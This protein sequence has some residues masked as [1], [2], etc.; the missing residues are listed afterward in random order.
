MPVGKESRLVLSD[1]IEPGP[2]FGW[3]APQSLEFL[4]RPSNEMLVDAHGQ[5][6][7]L[8]AIE[9]PVIVDPASHQGI[10]ALGE[11]RQGH[12]AAPIEVPVP[13][14]LAN[15]LPRLLAHG[16]R[17]AHKEPSSSFRP[18]SPEGI[19]E[20]VEA[21]VLEVP[22]AAAVLAVDDLRL[23][24]MQLL[25]ESPEPS[26][27]GGPKVPGLFLRVAV[28]HNVV[29]SCRVS[30]YAPKC[31]EHRPRGISSAHQMQSGSLIG[32]SLPSRR[33]P[34]IVPANHPSYEGLRIDDRFLN[35]R[36]AVWLP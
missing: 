35:A 31:S 12:A 23:V 33:T 27:D 6:V 9:G 1:S 3:L 26:S 14:L 10:D 20:E 34:C 17:K 7:Q 28:A 24:G 16:R 21:G 15:R 5:G 22:P 19:A 32:S 36:Y 8:G 13:D 29:C 18:A 11:T 25:S 30:N 4:H 2:C